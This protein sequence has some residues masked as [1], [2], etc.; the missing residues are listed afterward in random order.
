[1]SDVLISRQPQVLLESQQQQQQQRRVAGRQP[2]GARGQQAQLRQLHLTAA[3]HLDRPAAQP[4]PMRQQPVL[5]ATATAASAG[6]QRDGASA[7]GAGNAPALPNG[8]AEP[9]A[10]S[11]I[12]SAP[13]NQPIA[14]SAARLGSTEA[15]G[16]GGQSEQ[17]QPA[18]RT[19]PTNSVG[20]PEPNNVANNNS[21]AL[22]ASTSTSSSPSSP[23]H[24]SSS[25]ENSTLD[26][27]MLAALPN[28]VNGVNGAQKSPTR[29]SQSA[30]QQLGVAQNKRGTKR[31]STDDSAGLA[32]AD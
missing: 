6:Q 29:Q 5:T 14:A 1:M 13:V 4:L 26:E 7:A 30:P 3:G 10:S 16:G 20:G 31:K 32:S 8:I 2:P 25:L 18:R 27:P 12:E 15:A 21:T 28:G 11:P 24:S 9:R 19:S 22:A 17:R 23:S